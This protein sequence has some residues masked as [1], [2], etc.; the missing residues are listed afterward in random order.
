MT[1]WT[2]SLPSCHW[3]SG[4]ESVWDLIDMVDGVRT[5]CCTEWNKALSIYLEVNEWLVAT[6]VAEDES[7]DCHR[8]S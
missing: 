7:P 3:W 8:S 1:G 5:R 2:G 4:S 6:T